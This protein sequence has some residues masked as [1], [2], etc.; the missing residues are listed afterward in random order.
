MHKLIRKK[1]GMD[2]KTTKIHN[3]KKNHTKIE[4]EDNHY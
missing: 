4:Q 3:Q 1:K 2:N